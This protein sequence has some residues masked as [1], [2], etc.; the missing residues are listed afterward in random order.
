MP[1]TRN[2]SVK[3]GAAKG[4]EEKMSYWGEKDYQYELGVS[5]G[6]AIG[7]AIQ[8]LKDQELDEGLVNETIKYWFNK[9]LEMKSDPEV[10]AS[11]DAYYMNKKKKPEVKATKPGELPTISLE[12]GL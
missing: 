2:Y 11:F 12:E 6:A 1:Y 7:W 4:L 3:S 8:R 10:I 5:I 9:G